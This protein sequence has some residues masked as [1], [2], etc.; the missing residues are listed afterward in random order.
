MCPALSYVVLYTVHNQGTVLFP[1]LCPTHSLRGNNLTSTRQL[2]GQTVNSEAMATDAIKVD[3]KYELN[4]SCV[5]DLLCTCVC[6][7][8][9]VCVCMHV[10]V[11]VRVCACMFALLFV[12]KCMC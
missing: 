7:R 6:V 2:V 1:I 11:C 4:V 10:C 8:A 12:A 9:C 3:V 5:Y